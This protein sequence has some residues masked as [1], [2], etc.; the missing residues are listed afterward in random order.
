MCLTTFMCDT[1]RRTKI[2][3]NLSLM[4]VNIQMMPSVINDINILVQMSVIVLYTSLNVCVCMV[5]EGGAN[6]TLQRY[7]L[8]FFIIN[9]KA[10]KCREKSISLN[11]SPLSLGCMLLLIKIVPY[12][13]TE[14]KTINLIPITSAVLEMK[15][16]SL[17]LTSIMFSTKISNKGIMMGFV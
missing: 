3:H 14:E 6:E 9:F 5:E 10:F 1:R 7:F 13:L 8:F 2:C 15:F 11:V 17:P 12:H 16:V 4:D